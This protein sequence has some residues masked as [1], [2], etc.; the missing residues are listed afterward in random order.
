[1]K[2]RQWR[3]AKFTNLAGLKP[4]RFLRKKTFYPVETTITHQNNN[5]KKYF[6]FLLLL[7]AALLYFG[8][9]EQTK[10]TPS[11][12][13]STSPTEEVGATGTEDELVGYAGGG[14]NIWQ[15]T[16]PKDL[17]SGKA[18][19]NE[20]YYFAWKELL[21]L[22]WQSSYNTTTHE[23]GKPDMKWNPSTEKNPY[24]MNNPVVW[25]TYAHRQELSPNVGAMKNFNS[26]PKYV[27]KN[28][29]TKKVVDS[30]GVKTNLFNCLDENSEIGS[31]EIY[32][33]SKKDTDLAYPFLYQAKTNQDE[34]DYKK[35][36]VAE[37]GGM[38]SL[39]SLITKTA[40]NI[41]NLKGYW[42]E[43]DS[44]M[45]S[46]DCIGEDKKAK[47]F[48]LPCGGA[49]KKGG[50]TYEGAIEIK[51]AWR[52]KKTDETGDKHFARNALYYTQEIENGDT[53]IYSQNAVFLLEGIHIIHKTQNYPTFVIAT[54][55]HEG[56]Q[57]EDIA[58]V[59]LGGDT[60]SSDAGW[61]SISEPYQYS[62][63]YNSYVKVSN[64]VHQ[65][66]PANSIWRNYR[67]VGVQDQNSN[68][69]HMPRDSSYF[70]ANYVIE[71]DSMLG[72]F[73]GSFSAPHNPK[74]A[75]VLDVVPAVQRLKPIGAYQVK[76]MGGCKGCHGSAQKTG[77]DFSF[78]V[79]GQSGD[80]D[81]Y[82]VGKGNM[83][84]DSTT[85]PPIKY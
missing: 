85:I 38:D 67:L 18:S 40:S 47:A 49:E 7:N 12:A 65:Q 68:Y 29:K 83:Q 34:Y 63:T 81:V 43:N 69:D 79:S 26:A 16:P 17:S 55:E 57:S 84:T 8:C 52:K 21:A 70:L 5:M 45:G 56:V 25:E 54:F 61:H 10:K 71:S 24:P 41:K 4:N 50:G 20:L 62:R 36:L 58:F 82:Q 37:L 2:F 9:G 11:D 19:K 51:T 48:C 44:I 66:L 6:Y 39:N 74:S 13:P 33:F 3:P 73:V 28:T 1:M 32:A 64:D 46:C 59:G 30:P 76:S 22:S 23:R 80:P 75:F 14:D 42:M 77:S 78:I 31:C 53:T 15:P 27:Y 35:Q 72:Q 60:L